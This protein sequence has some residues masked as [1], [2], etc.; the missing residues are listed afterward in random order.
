[1]APTTTPLKEATEAPPPG[2]QSLSAIAY[3]ALRSRLRTGL[4]TP[5]DRLVDLE[6]AAQLGMSRMPV[7]EALL[8]LVAEGMLVSTTRG[9]RIPT[10][11][12]KDVMEV[13]ELRKLLEPRAAA[14]AA[15]DL[16]R[17]GI[18][19]LN[20]A[21]AEAKAALASGD[22]P[23]LFR[24]NVDFRETWIA[25]V[26]NKRLAAV[27]MRCADQVLTVRMSTLRGPEMHPVVVAR[28]QELYESFARHDSVAAHDSMYRF[29]LAA[30]SAYAAQREKSKQPA[31]PRRRL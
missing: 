24:A 23:R 6:I 21:L 15:R 29:V 26:R 8:Q 30:E 28:L 17:A 14:L 11:D 19:Q 7:R 4:V 3:D 1:M 5:E 13:F 9:Y 25:A 2:R 27:V 16:S 22:F 12:P 31:A 18:S 10:L 20:A